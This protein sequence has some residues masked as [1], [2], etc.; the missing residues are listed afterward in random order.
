MA[1]GISPFTK[2][3]LVALFN[4]SPKART[5]WLDTASDARAGRGITL[6]TNGDQHCKRRLSAYVYCLLGVPVAAGV[7][8]PF[9]GL[10][11]SPIIAGAAMSLSSVSVIGNALRLR[12]VD[13]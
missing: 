2:L 9:F 10:L 5:W 6:G 13:L 4:S 8:C 3:A 1:E 12:K 11:L 7:L